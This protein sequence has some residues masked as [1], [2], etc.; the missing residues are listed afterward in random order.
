MMSTQLASSFL[1]WYTEHPLKWSAGQPTSVCL[2]ARTE[3]TKYNN[4]EVPVYV[5]ERWGVVAL[6]VGEEKRSFSSSDEPINSYRSPSSFILLLLPLRDGW[7]NCRIPSMECLFQQ[8]GRVDLQSLCSCSR[9]QASPR[10]WLRLGK[11]NHKKPTP[12]PSII[13]DVMG[14]T[15]WLA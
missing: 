13:L 8:L 11:Q 7:I 4:G 14:P 15:L 3:S 12:V 1:R 6:C 9:G 2:L 10:P 5:L